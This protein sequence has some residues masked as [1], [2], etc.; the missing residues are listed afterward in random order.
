MKIITKAAFKRKQKPSLNTVYW[1]INFQPPT[2]SSEEAACI[3]SHYSFDLLISSPLFNH[4]GTVLASKVSSSLWSTFRNANQ[5][6]P[7]P[8]FISHC[9]QGEPE[10]LSVGHTV[11]WGVAHHYLS[12]LLSHPLRILTFHP[13]LWQLCHT[14]NLLVLRIY[15]RTPSRFGF[16][17]WLFFTVPSL[18]VS[19]KAFQ[20]LFQFR[21][22][23]SEFPSQP[24]SC[25]Y[26]SH[27]TTWLYWFISTCLPC[28]TVNSSGF[29]SM[30]YCLNLWGS[31]NTEWMKK[32]SFYYY[33]C[34][35]PHKQHAQQIDIHRHLE[36]VINE[37]GGST[38][39]LN[40]LSLLRYFCHP[41]Y[42]HTCL[43][44]KLW[45]I[46]VFKQPN[47]TIRAQKTN[48]PQSLVPCTSTYFPSKM[49]PIIW[50]DDFYIH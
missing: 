32:C 10:F 24:Y 33:P 25:Y 21:R 3:S 31:I 28:E 16:F 50:K 39:G 45:E 40:E 13:I 11:F 14:D 12:G 46:T 49:W 9:G 4:R 22:C 5:I 17:A 36:R 18:L 26:D 7:L 38:N 19:S 20:Y 27:H 37:T 43:I 2:L 29:Q 30:F 8:R 44:M 6:A 42:Y 47:N 34:P 35:I 48:N 41:K 23:F 1:P 15:Q